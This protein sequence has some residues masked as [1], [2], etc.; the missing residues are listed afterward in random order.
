MPGRA[1][2]ISVN[3]ELIYIKPTVEVLFDFGAVIYVYDKKEKNS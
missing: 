2:S 3:K 1:N